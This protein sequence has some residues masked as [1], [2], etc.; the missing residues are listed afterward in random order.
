MVGVPSAT[1]GSNQK[2]AF[3]AALKKWDGSSSEMDTGA[4]RRIE[5]IVK[6]ALEVMAAKCTP[7]PADKNDS[8]SRFHMQ[9]VPKFLSLQDFQSQGMLL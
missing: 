4:L 6:K 7:I 1:N 9:K 8:H 5:T 2:A 3:K